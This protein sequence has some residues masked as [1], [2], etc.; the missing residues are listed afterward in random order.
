MR[1]GFDLR[2]FLRQETGVGVYFRN[3]LRELAALDRDNEYFLFSSSWKD[4]FPSAKLPAFA[5]MRFR[6]VRL[7][8]K[9][10]NFLWY[11]L[12]RPRLDLFFRARLDLTHSPVP[13]FLPTGGK[14]VITVCDLFF[15][16]HP[17]L[18]DKE[19][20]R[21]FAR[22]VGRA[23]ER[24]DAVITISEYSR[25]VIVQQLSADRDKVRAIPLGLD[26]VFF[27]EIAPEERAAERRTLDLPQR[28]LLFVG[29]FEPRK[30]LT[31]LVEALRIIHGRAEKI[32]LVIAG[33]RGGD[34]E[35]VQAGIRRA[36]LEE[37][38]RAVGYVP[39]GELRRL[40]RLATVFVFP[41]L[42]EGFG[43]P[44]LEAMASGLPVAASRTSAMPEVAGEAAAYFDPSQP[45]DMAATVIKL[46]EDEALR[47][48]LAD[49]GKVRARAFSWTAT[50]RRTLDLYR[51]LE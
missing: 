41:S 49:R 48:E 31:A 12:G 45:E 47:S 2:P 50:A 18:A 43:L 8:V 3:L 5:R 4:R 1:I 32:P 6:D 39:D 20:R 44:I 29:A 16:E 19:A 37:Y 24:A 27:E 15:L 38:I 23:V 11:R 9:V 30:N 25:K 14:K 26:S 28:F 42:A 36:G 10:L 17:E 13:L 7:P 51:S 35:N 22:S 46:L 34:Y 21:T 40:Y 33:R